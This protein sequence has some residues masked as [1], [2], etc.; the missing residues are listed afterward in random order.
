MP[1]SVAEEPYP[2]N[3]YYS[4]ITP[5]GSVLGLTY[6]L[7]DPSPA[8]SPNVSSN[9]SWAADANRPCSI[10][11]YAHN[12]ERHEELAI[13]LSA[14]PEPGHPWTV[15]PATADNRHS[16]ARAPDA[17]AGCLSHSDAPMH[18]YMNVIQAHEFLAFALESSSQAQ[19][20]PQQP[21]HL[22]PPE[23]AKE[24]PSTRWT[25]HA[26]GVDALEDGEDIDVT[27][28]SLRL[29]LQQ[30]QREKY[31]KPN[32][33]PKG[34]RKNKKRSDVSPQPGHKDKMPRWS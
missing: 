32:R 28:E 2:S 14:A 26:S 22:N 7:A 30:Q 21:H 15:G 11:R 17:K 3:H 18:R 13:S 6:G 33:N 16:F 5:E 25:M 1:S 10:Y 9:S 29:N 8:A 34:H 19:P 4:D 24:P 23:P 31:Q 20:P 12:H 27:E